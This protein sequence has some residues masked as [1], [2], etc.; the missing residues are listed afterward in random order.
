MDIKFYTSS[1]DIGVDIEAIL[2]S[3]AGSAAKLRNKQRNNYFSCNFIIL[4]F[5]IIKILNIYIAIIN[6]TEFL[7]ITQIL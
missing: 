3:L 2:N 6:E 5:G 4:N 7:T 1:S